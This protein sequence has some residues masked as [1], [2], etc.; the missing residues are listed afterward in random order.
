MNRPTKSYFQSIDDEDSGND[1]NST[2]DLDFGIQPDL[3]IISDPTS[4][5]PE[6]DFDRDFSL[7]TEIDSPQFDPFDPKSEIPDYEYDSEVSTPYGFTFEPGYTF[8]PEFTGQYTDEPYTMFTFPPEFTGQPYSDG[9][10][11]PPDFTFDPSTTPYPYDFTTD[12]YISELPPGKD[13]LPVI[14]ATCGATGS[15]KYS[16]LGFLAIDR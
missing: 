11:F 2:D 5:D 12:Q 3:E 7:D 10:T 15:L 14:I 6:Q 1:K 13:F 9:F 8:P 4:N 16:R